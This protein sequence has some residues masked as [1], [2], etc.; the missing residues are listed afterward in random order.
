MPLFAALAE[1][2]IRLL[3]IHPG[4]FGDALRISLTTA[5][6]LKTASLFSPTPE[7]IKHYPIH[8]EMSAALNA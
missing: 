5:K 1:N 4:A 3:M 6:S 2:E 7:P 8:G